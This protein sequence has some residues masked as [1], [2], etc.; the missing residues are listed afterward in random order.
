MVPLISPRAGRSSRSR[1]PRRLPKTDVLT[2]TQRS[3]G[4]R[5]IWQRRDWKHLI[6]DKRDY[7]HHVDYV[8]LKSAE[9]W[10]RRPPHRLAIFESSSSGRD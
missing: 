10:G 2:A 4:E 9:A 3:R 8:H 5:G 7:R 6:R 1:S